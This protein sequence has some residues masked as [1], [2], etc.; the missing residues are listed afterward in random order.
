MR[1]GWIIGVHRSELEECGRWPGISV[2][3]D[4]LT[5]L[6]SL[7]AFLLLSFS[8]TLT[9]GTTAPVPVL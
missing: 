7:S 2:I 1:N 3:R 9:D 6:Y 4:L 8:F 5:A